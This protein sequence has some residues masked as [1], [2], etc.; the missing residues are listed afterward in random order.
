MRILE[1]AGM[2]LAAVWTFEIVLFLV[3]YRIV[4]RAPR[5]KAVRRTV[6]PTRVRV[7]ASLRT[8]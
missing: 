6:P 8:S 5:P 2:V 3:T 1:I 7:P 4:N